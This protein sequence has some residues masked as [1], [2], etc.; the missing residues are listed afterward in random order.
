MFTKLIAAV[1][2]IP[3]FLFLVFAVTHFP[4]VPVEAVQ[5]VKYVFN[6]YANAAHAN[7]RDTRSIQRISY[8]ISN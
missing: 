4:P 1:M 3:M 7:E 5:A 6:H 2:A 8:R